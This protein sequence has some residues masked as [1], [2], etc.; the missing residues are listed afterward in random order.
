M[1]REND[2]Q[3][4]PTVRTVGKWLYSQLSG[5]DAVASL[6]SGR[7]CPFITREPQ[8]LPWIV[9]DNVEIDWDRDKDSN[10][11]TT[12]SAVIMCA[13]ATADAS[14]ELVDAVIGALNDRNSCRVT[15]IN[16]YWQDGV[17]VIQEISVT[18]DLY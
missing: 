1:S 14:Y 11:P 4:P 6:T 16:A 10:D 7:I 3:I 18:I 13:A 8:Q 12:A 15:H 9:W 5:D 17:G 2:I